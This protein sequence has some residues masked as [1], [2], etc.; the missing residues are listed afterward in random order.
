[1]FHKIVMAKMT[2]SSVTENITIN[3]HGNNSTAT[4]TFPTHI[5]VPSIVVVLLLAVVIGLAV[6]KRKTVTFI[7]NKYL[8]A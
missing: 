8:L 3:A 6:W 4:S 2:P 1:M 5:L 7:I